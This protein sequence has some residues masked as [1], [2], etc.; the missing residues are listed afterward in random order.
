M[1]PAREVALRAGWWVV[2]GLAVLVAAAALGGLVAPEAR[3]PVLAEHLE[4]SALWIVL[5]VA[6]GVVAL[7]VG[8]AQANP[9]LRRRHRTLH[10]RLGR[11][12][13]I[14]VMAS[15]LAG[16]MLA[17]ASSSGPVARLGFA[18]LAVCWLGTTG[19]G[20]ALIRGDDR[21]GHGR[22]MIRSYALTL[23]AVMLRIYLPL[24]GA[25]GIAFEVAYPVIAWACWVPNL[26]VAELLLTRGVAAPR[27][28]REARGLGVSNREARGLAGK[29]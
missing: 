15:A 28:G 25:L 13:V 20:A 6:G 22:W 7:L 29:P 11:I 12:Y 16:A 19:A 26:V 14:V 21:V 1:R 2:A 24:S 17:A 9:R 5:H 4:R 27:A 8:A 10:E 23:A 18:G 3:S